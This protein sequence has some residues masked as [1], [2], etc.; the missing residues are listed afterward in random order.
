[1]VEIPFCI[2]IGVKDQSMVGVRKL[3]SLLDLNQLLRSELGTLFDRCPGFA[4]INGP[5][6]MIQFRHCKRNAQQCNIYDLTG[7]RIEGTRT[8][9]RDAVPSCLLEATLAQISVPS[10]D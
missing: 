7:D 5:K 6:R 2:L 3:V 9:P 8:Q 10:E 1:M 4:N